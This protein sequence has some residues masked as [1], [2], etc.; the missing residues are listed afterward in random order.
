MVEL[1]QGEGGVTA[2]DK[3]YAKYVEEVCMENGI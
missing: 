1:V 2:I 3:S